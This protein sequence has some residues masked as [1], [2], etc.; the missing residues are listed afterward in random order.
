ME[1]NEIFFETVKCDDGVAYNLDYHNRRIART[2][3]INIYLQEYIL[4]IS[5]ELLKCKVLYDKYGVLDVLFERYKKREIKS[6]KLI[7]D[8][9]IIYKNKSTN[10]SQLEKLFD[11]KNEADEIII[12]K[13]GLV[14]DTSIANIAIFDGNIWLTPK[15]SLLRGTTQERLI[16]NKQLIQTDISVEMLKKAKKI[17][18]LNAMIGMDVLENYSFLE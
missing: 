7:Y 2:I 13:N 8:D 4:P 17:A 5:D 6:F 16:E 1:K 18:L 9:N 11:L 15:T 14:T 3:M 10:R 12:I